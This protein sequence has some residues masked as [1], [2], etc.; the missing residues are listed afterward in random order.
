[1]KTIRPRL[2]RISVFAATTA[3]AVA[4]ALAVEPVRIMPL[5]DSITAG[6]T[7]N[8]TW[9][10]PFGFGYRSGLYTR[11]TN[12]NYPFQYAGASQEPWNGVFGVPKTVSAP[13]LRTVNEDFHRGYGGVDAV[14]L[15]SNIGNW[16]S[17]DTPDVMLLMIGINSISQGGTSNPTTAE[18]NLNAL[19]Q[20][21]V[22][23]RPTAH[24]VV[25]QITPYSTYTSSIVQYNAYIKNTLVPYFTGLGKNVTTVDQYSNFGTGTTVDSGLY[26][27]GIN[28]PNAV[29]YDRMAQ[30]WYD[31]I[32][33]LGTIAHTAGP[34]QAVLSNGSFESPQFSNNTHNINPGDAAW[35]FTPSSAGAG[36]GID[37]GNPYGVTNSTPS[38]GTQMSFLQGAGTGNGTCSISQNMTGLI[39]GK[40]YNLSFSAKGINGFSGTNPFSVSIGNSTLNIG[41]NTVLTPTATAN[42]T[43]YSTTFIAT[44]SS[45]PIRFFDAGN[46]AVQKVTWIDGVK[47]GIATPAGSN[48]VTNGTFEANAYGNNTHN[49]NPSGTG[50]RFT[51]GGT[52][53]GSGIDRGNPYGSANASAYEGLQYAFLQGRGEG[54]GVTGIEQDVS[55]L[56]AGESY[57]LSFESAGIEGFSGANPFFVSLGGNAVEFNGS[58]YVS[59]SASYGLYVSTPIVATSSTMTLRFYDAGN[60]PVGFASWIDDV[61]MTAVPEPPAGVSLLGLAVISLIGGIALLSSRKNA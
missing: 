39:V 48:L 52:T 25:A 24:V 16:L 6:Y 1:M 43:A 5:G 44:S 7:D 3:F 34:A 36:S 51:P 12:A 60:V 9:N 61:Q 13:D 50:W 38:S 53:A 33:A 42:Y 18:N 29:G 41:G 11:L 23:Q 21:I 17:T 10:V 30:T 4:S 8:P 47:L 40:T 20:S 56:L 26:A 15:A 59:P 32:Q 22:Y 57:M 27:N 2:L 46:V 58:T 54:N 55:G 35:T 14:F 45:M 31:G 28:H 49:V 37:R 19:V